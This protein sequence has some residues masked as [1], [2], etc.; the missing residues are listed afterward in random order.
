[1]R[2]PKAIVLVE[3]ADLPYRLIKRV[4]FF[5]NIQNLSDCFA[6]KD[7][8]KRFQNDSG[9]AKQWENNL[10][11]EVRATRLNAE[12]LSQRSEGQRLD[13]WLL[14]NDA[15]PEKGYWKQLAS[16]I[17]TSPEALHRTVAKNHDC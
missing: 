8:L 11:S 13:M 7:I 3:S 12:I 9:Y 5:Q 15:L 17:G 10:A 16:E 2:L 6:R 4:K 14:Q 1:M